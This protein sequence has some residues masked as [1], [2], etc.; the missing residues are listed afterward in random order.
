MHRGYRFDVRPMLSPGANS[1]TVDLRSAL[2]YAED[3]ER[4]LGKRPHTNAHPYNMVRKMAC[5]FGWDWGPDFQTAGLW[6]PVRLERWHISRSPARS[7]P[8][9]VRTLPG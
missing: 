5:S 6:K 2:E 7:R 4:A 3:V 8:R 9:S 1:L